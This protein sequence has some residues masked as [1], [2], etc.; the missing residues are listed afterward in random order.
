MNRYLP[1]VRRLAATLCLG[2]VFQS[3]AEG[4]PWPAMMWALAGGM[5]MAI[6]GVFIGIE[7]ER[8]A[9]L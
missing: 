4:D 9:R 8:K 6:D 5:W 1:W 2:L 3:A 7:S